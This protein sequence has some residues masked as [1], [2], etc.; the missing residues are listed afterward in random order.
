[1]ARL[2]ARMAGIGVRGAV[3]AA[4]KLGCNWLVLQQL[5]IPGHK[6]NE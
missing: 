6:S 1:M 4:V 2:S 5:Y 3:L